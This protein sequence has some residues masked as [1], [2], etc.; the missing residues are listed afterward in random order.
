MSRNSRRN[1][2]KIKKTDQQ[3]LFKDRNITNADIY[4]DP[5][6]FYPP[7][8]IRK[9][10]NYKE[11]YWSAGDKYFKLSYKYYGNR[12]DWW[13]IARFNGKPTDADLS[14]GDRLVIPFPLDIVKDYMGYYGEY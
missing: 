5:F 3:T 6:L 10:L 1:I 4:Q 8:D 12:S 13:V 2:K 14:I 9:Q 11:H 7:E